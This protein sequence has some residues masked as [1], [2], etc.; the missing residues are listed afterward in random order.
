MSR[1]HRMFLGLPWWECP[2][3]GCSGEPQ[4]GSWQSWHQKLKIWFKIL[5]W[6][7]SS[8]LTKCSSY[9]ND[10]GSLTDQ[11]R[12]WGGAR[13]PRFTL[14]VMWRP[15]KLE[16]FLEDVIYFFISS[17]PHF[18]VRRPARNLWNRTS[19]GL[20]PL[21]VPDGLSSAE[22]ICN[23]LCCFAKP[24]LGELQINFFNSQK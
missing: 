1:W 9:N 4:T 23:A 20:P 6:E 11:K 24:V 8:C 19:Q 22:D 16:L 15:L 21:F 10:Y 14:R 18:L 5:V 2:G 7:N 13:M 17:C 3:T 12:W